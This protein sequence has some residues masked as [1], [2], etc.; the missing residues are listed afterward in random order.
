MATYRQIIDHV[1]SEGG[2]SPKT[3]WVAHVLSDHGLTDRKAP[4]RDEPN[5][6]MHPCPLSKRT[7]I[8]AALRYFA[9]I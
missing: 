6:R 9:M 8:E 7:A 2:F 4:N 1:R 3:C 5:L